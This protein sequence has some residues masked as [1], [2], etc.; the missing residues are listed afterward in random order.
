MKKGVIRILFVVFGLLTIT[1]GFGQKRPRMFERN[2]LHKNKLNVVSIYPA[3]VLNVFDPSFQIGYDR[4]VRENVIIQL[5]GGIIL[6]HSIF[7]YIGIL[8]NPDY[9]RFNGFKIMGEI[10]YILAESI[11]GRHNL[12]C[13]L[14]AFYK[15]ERNEVH[16]LVSP[17]PSEPYYTD[18]FTVHKEVV[19]A[20]LKFGMQFMFGRMIMEFNSGIG[21]RHNYVIQTNRDNPDDRLDG[22]PNHLHRQGKY[23]RLYLPLHYKIGYRF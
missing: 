20:G 19:G 22:T 3:G 4:K 23:Y 15:K 13:S 21:L 14:E 6:P 10:K 12:F 9:Y 11:S 1:D 2:N 7:G 8:P 17:G 16:G 5:S 18:Y